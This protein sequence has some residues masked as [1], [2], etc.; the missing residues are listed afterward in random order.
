MNVLRL[1]LLLAMV[2]ALAACDVVGGGGGDGG[3]GTPVAGRYEVKVTVTRFEVPG[4][5]LPKLNAMQ[6]AM[7]GKQM[8]YSYCLSSAQAAK[9][10]EALFEQTGEGA[11]ALHQFDPQGGKLDVLMTC[12][13]VSGRQSFALKGTVSRRSA[14]FV[15]DGIVTNGRFPRG[16]ALI[17]RTIEMKKIAECTPP[18]PVK[19]PK[20]G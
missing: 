1:L 13:A 4:L 14:K 5:D 3:G 2:P 8:T 7:V 16:R 15:E 11:C 18:A 12:R 17:T 10:G 6:K 20:V 19:K 9:K